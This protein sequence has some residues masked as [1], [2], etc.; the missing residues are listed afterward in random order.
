VRA[1]AR[2]ASANE[3]ARV[4][5]GELH[6]H[7]GRLRLDVCEPCWT[8]GSRPPREVILNLPPTV[9]MSTP[10]L[11][12]DSSSG[13]AAHVPRR[14][15]IV[16]RCIRTTTAAARWPRPSSAHG[17]RRAR[18][19]STV[20]KRRA[21]GQRR[22]RDARLNLQARASTRASTSRHR[23]ARRASSSTC[24]RLP[25]HHRHP[26]VGELVYTRFSGSHQDAIKKGMDALGSPRARLGGAVPLI[27]P[28]DVGRTYEAGIRVN[29]QSGK[30]GVPTS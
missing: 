7:G 11:Y 19:G 1:R 3:S 21:D 13:S 28:K 17:R 16:S 24:N 14:D 27:D 15:A 20:R 4:L 8:S 5:A 10:N 2:R 22:P 18:R 26:Y 30:G 25:V 23:R 9:E 29:S 6:G 12:A